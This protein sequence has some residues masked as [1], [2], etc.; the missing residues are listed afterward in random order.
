MCA[1]VC[2]YATKIGNSFPRCTNFLVLLQFAMLRHARTC[3]RACVR[4]S[5]LFF[6]YCCK[7]NR[8]NRHIIGFNRAARAKVD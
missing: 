6:G 3:E 4:A 8:S 5:V 2:A 1:Y 7:V